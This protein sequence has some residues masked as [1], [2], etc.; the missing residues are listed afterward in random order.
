MA[1]DFSNGFKQSR[2]CFKWCNISKMMYG[3]KLQCTNY[4][5]N[6]SRPWLRKVASLVQLPLVEIWTRSVLDNQQI[7]DEQL[8]YLVTTTS[9]VVPAGLARLGWLACKQNYHCMVAG[10]E[11][12]KYANIK[13][14]I[15]NNR[16]TLEQTVSCFS[17]STVSTASLAEFKLQILFL[18]GWNSDGCSGTTNQALCN[19]RAF[20]G[21][22]RARHT[23]SHFAEKLVQGDT[24]DLGDPLNFS[25][26]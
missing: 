17:V 24:G 15:N 2:C 3:C 23:S 8:W 25:P 13:C 19:K 18:C 10:S 1:P 6:N 4:L 11:L 21:S 26:R 14:Q 7:L 12:Q 5:W 20:E 9:T 16:K 22:L